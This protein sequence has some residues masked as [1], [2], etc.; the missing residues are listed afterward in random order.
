MLSQIKRNWMIN[1]FEMPNMSS[2]L[3]SMLNLIQTQMST[4]NDRKASGIK[5]IFTASLKQQTISFQH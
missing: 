5:H 4:A 2:N 1:S 3:Y